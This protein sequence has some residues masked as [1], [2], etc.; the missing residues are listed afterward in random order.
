MVENSPKEETKDVEE[1]R[2]EYSDKWDMQIRN[3][4]SQKSS[5]QSSHQNSANQSAQPEVPII[6]DVYDLKPA[7]K[8]RNFESFT[9]YMHNEN[10]I[11][12]ND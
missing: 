10:S 3:E 2:S 12:E 6:R 7:V 9:G 1:M 8:G 4:Q 11:D 5:Q